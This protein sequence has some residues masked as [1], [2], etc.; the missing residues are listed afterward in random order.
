LGYEAELLGYEAKFLDYEAK[1]LDYEVELLGYEAELLGYEVRD[2]V[3]GVGWV[4]TTLRE[5]KPTATLSQ[6]DVLLY[7]F[8]LRSATGKC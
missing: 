3:G 4:V 8:G 1:F 5:G 7:V 2:V 6:R